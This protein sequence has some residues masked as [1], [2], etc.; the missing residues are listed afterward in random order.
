MSIF[1]N[2]F[3][4]RRPVGRART[5]RA[6]GEPAAGGRHSINQAS[7]EELIA[8]PGIGEELAHAIV[9]WRKEHGPFRSPDDLR[10]I[11][12]INDVRVN[13]IREHFDF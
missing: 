13:Y 8:I 1:S 10:Q 4:R 12:Q 11:Q 9:D 5:R 6:G 2:L 7:V 3:P